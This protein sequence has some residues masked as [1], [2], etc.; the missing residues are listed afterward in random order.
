MGKSM[1]FSVSVEA[2]FI[3][4]YPINEI[5]IKKNLQSKIFQRVLGSLNSSGVSNAC[6]IEAMI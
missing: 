2:S 6:W 5:M 3:L 4:V 1:S